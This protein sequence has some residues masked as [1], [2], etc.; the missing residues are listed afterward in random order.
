MVLYTPISSFLKGAHVRRRRKEHEELG[1][2]AVNTSDWPAEVS[3]GKATRR[4][5]IGLAIIALPC[6]L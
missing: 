1:D 6:V 2:L 3:T 4:E 5:W